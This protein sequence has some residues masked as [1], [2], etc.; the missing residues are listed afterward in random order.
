MNVAH[1]QHSQV[2][3]HGVA[4]ILICGGCPGL[5]TS[6][7]CTEARR[8]KLMP[9]RAG[10]AVGFLIPGISLI[11]ADKGTASLTGTVTQ[12]GPGIPKLEVQSRTSTP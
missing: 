12:N 8:R 11:A 3:L 9:F 5:G 2:G 7:R 4:I 10:L 6:S 1:P